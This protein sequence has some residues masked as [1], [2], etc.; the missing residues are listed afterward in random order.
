MS[1]TS[2]NV[3]HAKASTFAQ[4]ILTL[5]GAPLSFERYKPWKLIYD[6]MPN[7][8]LLIA[9]RQIGKSVSLGGRSVTQ[10]IARQHFN[11]LYVTPFA[12][13]AKRFSKAYLDPFMESH[14]VKKYF[15]DTGTTKNVLEKSFTSGSRIYLSYAQDE[16]DADR[17]RGVMADQLMY[18][19]VQDV[20]LSAL[21]AIFETL[22]ASEHGFKILSGTAKSTSNTIE[23]LWQTT[24]KFEWIMKCDR[25]NYYN[26]PDTYDNCLKICSNPHYPVCMRCGN[27]IDV[28]R[29]QWVATRPSIK[30]N[31]GFH[32]PQLV[33]SANTTPKKW[34]EMYN[35]VQQAIK[36]GMYSPAKLSNEVFGIST[37]LAGKTLS[38]R[39]AMQCSN[40]EQLGY[41]DVVPSMGFTHVILG[42]DWSVTS[43]EKS[44]TV[45][46][47]FGFLPNGKMLLIYAEKFQGI[48]ILLQIDRIADI[49][50][51]YRCDLIASDRGVGVVQVQTLQQRLGVDKVVP[52][53]YVSAKISVRWDKEAYF[54]AADRTRAIDD[55]IMKIKHGRE[56]FE[57]P[58]YDHIK[59]LWK[60]ALNVYEEETSVHTRV[61]RHHPDEPDDWLHSCVFAY[62]GYKFLTGQYHFIDEKN[63]VVSASAGYQDLYLRESQLI[64]PRDEYPI[65]SDYHSGE[66]YDQDYN[67]FNSY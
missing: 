40:P 32:L 43:S 7:F 41:Y 34:P 13:Q 63:G 31:I 52:I 46:S 2:G 4:S 58:C 28:T 64:L 61:Y 21:P 8:M 65:V 51:K 54:L 44:F 62:I 17:I 27:K 49:Y 5:K 47:V 57:T 24:C 14:L 55:V 53:N 33:M 19:E 42:V 59:H 12:E 56:R 9:G 26:I 38:V 3:V 15:K 29:G 39:D 36:G 11:S 66:F 18:D 23:F 48:D 6:I 22:S 1:A 35:K 45:A 25:C 60:D 50:N 30:Q 10:S 37:D 67:D 16:T 20:I